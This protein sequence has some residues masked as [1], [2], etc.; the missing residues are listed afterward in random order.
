[1]TRIILFSGFMLHSLQIASSLASEGEVCTTLEIT[2]D[3][4]VSY[5]NVHLCLLGLVVMS[6]VFSA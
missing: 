1:M 5:R 4:D 2:S 3:V 6:F